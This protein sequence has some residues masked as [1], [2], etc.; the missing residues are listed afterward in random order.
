M[1]IYADMTYICSITTKLLLSMNLNNQYFFIE[2][3]INKQLY[4]YI[5]IYLILKLHFT[6]IFAH[7]YLSSISDSARVSKTSFYNTHVI[8]LAAETWPKFRHVRTHSSNTI[9]HL[10]N[11]HFVTWRSSFDGIMMYFS[12]IFLVSADETIL[13]GTQIVELTTEKILELIESAYPNP[14][15]I[16]DLAE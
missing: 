1:Q 12:K 4:I 15:T 11:T 7:E 14:L 2:I 10:T 16:Q 13:G 8:I 5:Y 9:S 6:N 3:F